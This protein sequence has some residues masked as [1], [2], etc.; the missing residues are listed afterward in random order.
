[1]DESTPI[2]SS[3]CDS[4]KV[5]D[6]RELRGLAILARRGSQIVRLSGLKYKVRSQSGNGAYLTAMDNSHE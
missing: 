5:S 2:Y 3:L 1:M 4:N 6:S